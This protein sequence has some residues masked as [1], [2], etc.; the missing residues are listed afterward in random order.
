[1]AASANSL[2]HFTRREPTTT[3][4]QKKFLRHSKTLSI[5]IKL[6]AWFPIRNNPPLIQVCLQ[7]LQHA[8]HTFNRLSHCDR[9]LPV[10]HPS[11]NNHHQSSITCPT[12]P[13][14]FPS[15]G[16]FVL[17]SISPSCRFCV[18][19]NV[20]RKAFVGSHH[21]AADSN[22]DSNRRYS[23]SRSG[24]SASQSTKCSISQS[25][26]ESIKWTHFAA[27]AGRSRRQRQV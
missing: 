6:L 3:L 21:G 25:T 7:R 15:P 14:R 27:V 24:Q 9:G 2:F 22:N 4:A 19:L 20:S 18:S 5:S 12:S 13:F 8:H 16:K 23:H 11:S 26:R 1:V 10:Q 17:A